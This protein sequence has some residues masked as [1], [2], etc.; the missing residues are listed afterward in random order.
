MELILHPEMTSTCSTLDCANEMSAADKTS[1]EDE[2]WK[3]VLLG[4]NLEANDARFTKG[5]ETW[6][7][8]E[9]VVS[10]DT[11]EYSLFVTVKESEV[12]A[13]A[14]EV[15]DQLADFLA[16]S[17]V[18]YCIVFLSVATG[19]FCNFTSNPEIY[20]RTFLCE[21]GCL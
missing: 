17:V 6:L 16:A 10:L 20:D 9:A 19:I 8:R 13:A 11:S 12:L 3:P 7:V 21:I 14:I 4:E 2:V 18:V 15:E 5:E 1:F